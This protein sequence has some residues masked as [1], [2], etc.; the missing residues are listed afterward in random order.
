M[1]KQTSIAFLLILALN[2]PLFA[3]TPPRDG[4][5]MPDAYLRLQEKDLKAFTY[6]RAL[7]ALVSTAQRNREL[8]EISAA[9]ARLSGVA[10]VTRV[11]EGIT[12]VSGEMSIPVLLLRF[13]NTTGDASGHPLFASSALQ[14]KLFDGDPSHPGAT[15]GSFYREMSYNRLKVTGTVFDWKRLSMPDTYYEGRDYTGR[16]GLPAHC[17]GLC[18]TGGMGDLIREALELNRDIDWTQY[19][20]D[21]PDGKPNSGDDDGYVDFVA[22]AHAEKGSE[23]DR[24]TNIWSH[25]SSLSRWTGSDYQTTSRRVNGGFI[26][27]DD[28]T[29]QP[30]YGCNGTTPND[31]GVYAHE[32]GHAFGLPDLYDTSGNGQGLGNWCLMSSGAWGGDGKSPDQPVQMSPWAKE[33][34][35]W[36]KPKDIPGDLKPALIETYEDHDDVYRLRISRTQYYLID[37]LGKKLSN[38]KLPVAGVQ[39]WLVNQKRVNVG[40]QSNTVNVDP[41]YGVELIEAHGGRLLHTRDY[42][43]GDGDLFPGLNKD[44]RSFDS[45]TI[46]KNIATTAVCEIDALADRALTRFLIN[47]HL[48]PGPAPPDQPAPVITSSPAPA[49]PSAPRPQRQGTTSVSE[50]LADPQRFLDQDV[51]ITGKLENKGANIQLRKGRD[52]QLSDSSGSIPVSSIWLPLEVQRSGTGSNKA[53][54]TDVLNENVRA[55]ARV[56]IDPNTGRPRLTIMSAVVVRQ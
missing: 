17:N 27:I 55:L 25:R 45:G 14:Q 32:F 21:G 48:C 13:R 22:F 42:F 54:V 33:V 29:I 47:S 40:L 44:K 41:D 18:E 5:A 12:E 16:N 56:E 7:E 37:N 9:S 49:A 15:I 43:G 34:L 35:G 38:S 52:F 30:A 46:P 11:Q 6:K 53:T 36:V 50:I 2:T 28:Y 51:Q 1:L 3:T 20:N 23:C 31:I 24:G 39:I 8:D 26:R 10:N 19:D 4:G